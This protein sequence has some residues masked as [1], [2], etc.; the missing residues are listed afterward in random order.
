MPKFKV[1]MQ[2]KH[3]NWPKDW[4]VGREIKLLECTFKRKSLDQSQNLSVEVE[5]YA[6]DENEAME[7]G[8]N[9]ISKEFD[10]FALCAENPLYLDCD[11]VLVDRM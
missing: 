9:T 10:L 3:L 8:A 2:G 11:Y 6:S 5:V 7:L 1:H 4:D